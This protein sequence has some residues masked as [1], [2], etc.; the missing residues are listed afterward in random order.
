MVSEAIYKCLNQSCNT[1]PLIDGYERLSKALDKR[2]Y[3]KVP[4]MLIH[5]KAK[6]NFISQLLSIMLIAIT[7]IAL[8]GIFD[9]PFEF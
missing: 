9:Y 8:F 6:C 4:I 5:C 1:V 3:A 2:A 7:A